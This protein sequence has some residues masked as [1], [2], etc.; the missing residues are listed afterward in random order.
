METWSS[1]G[2]DR[3]NHEVSSRPLY[4][5][6]PFSSNTEAYYSEDLLDVKTIYEFWISDDSIL[7][8]I[9]TQM[10]NTTLLT[11][12]NAP[13]QAMWHTR[14]IVRHGGT[15]DEARFAQ[16]MGLAIARQFDI[17]TG[18]ITMVDDIVF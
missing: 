18:D 10:C 1:A 11:C 5:S 2:N 15:L 9:E 7:S 17:Q 12:W 14:G 6:N 8:N 13:V 16:D 4:A 3:P